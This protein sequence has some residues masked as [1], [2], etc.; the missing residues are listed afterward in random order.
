M[1]V[2]NMFNVMMNMDETDNVYPKVSKEESKKRQ[3]DH[4]DLSDYEDDDLKDDLRD[5]DY[6][7]AEDGTNGKRSRMNDGSMRRRG[8]LP[9]IPKMISNAITYEDNGTIM[10]RITSKPIPMTIKINLGSSFRNFTVE[11]ANAVISK[12][13]IK[14]Q[15]DLP[16]YI[17]PI[18]VDIKDP[19]MKNILNT[20]YS[21]YNR[22][23]TK[24]ERKHIIMGKKNYKYRL[25][26]L[27]GDRVYYAGLDYITGSTFKLKLKTEHDPLV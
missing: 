3:L 12:E 9:K 16:D 14:V 10:Y 17:K 18:T 1:D 6:D 4:E 20:M 19:T 13:P 5:E 7:P 15:M 23:L 21:V 8:P 22:L 2:N 25:H 24:E 27:L 26:H 11:Y